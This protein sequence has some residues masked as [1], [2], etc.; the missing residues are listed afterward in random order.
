MANHQIGNTLELAAV[1]SQSTLLCNVTA[2]GVNTVT[3]D[4]L[5]KIFAGQ[6]VDIVNKATGA[7][8]ASART[9]TNITSAGVVTYNGGDVTAVA[10]THGLYPTGTY[11][12]GSA[13]VNANG[14]FADGSG[15][16]IDAVDTIDAARARLTAIN[17]TIY[18]AARL[19]QMTFNDMLYAIRVNDYPRSIKQ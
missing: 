18:T 13:K 11:G 7:V 9:I 16:D 6:V 3:V 15:F 5:T 10:G 4:D 1:G 2:D 14:G 8:L 17:G 12:T 19:N